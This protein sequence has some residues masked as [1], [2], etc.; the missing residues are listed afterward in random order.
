MNYFF[1]WCGTL[2]SHPELLQLA[3]LLHAKGHTIH[4]ISGTGDVDCIVEGLSGKP[5]EILLS[6]YGIPWAIPHIK[7]DVDAQETA[8]WKAETMQRIG[9]V[10]MFWDDLPWNV[11]AARKVGIPATLVEK[12]PYPPGTVFLP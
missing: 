10:G 6:L 9:G 11:E 3:K 2:D 1:D 4:V 8:E 12:T 7:H 5:Y